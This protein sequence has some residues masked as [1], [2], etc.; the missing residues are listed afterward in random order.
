MLS[1]RG[2]FV[3]VSLLDKEFLK[4][5]EKLE[6]ELAA[7]RTASEDHRRHIEILDQALS[8]AQARVI[9]L[10]EEVRWGWG[11][12]PKGLCCLYPTGTPQWSQLQG[13][14]SRGGMQQASQIKINASRVYPAQSQAKCEWQP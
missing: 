2:S 10:E 1:N 8:N 4:E 11:Q 3:L 6:M 14:E 7:V 9:K 5:K 13:F 12:S